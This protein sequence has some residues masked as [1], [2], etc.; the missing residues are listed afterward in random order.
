MKSYLTFFLVFLAC[1]SNAQQKVLG[2]YNST[3]EGY[4][5][6]FK[7]E[8]PCPVTVKVKFKLTNLQ[9][10]KPNQHLFILPA[11]ADSF[12]IMTLKKI[13]PKKAYSFSW[14]YDWRNGDVTKLNETINDAYFL[15]FKKGL[16]IEIGQ[17]YNGKF[18][19]HNENALDFSLPYGS[20]IYSVW[21][22]V[23]IDVV[24]N[25]SKSCP[26]KDCAIYN[27]YITIYHTNGTI[28]QYAHIKQNGSLLKIGDNVLKGQL[29][30]FSGDVGWSNGP[31]LHFVCYKETFEKETIITL[32]TKFLTGKGATREFLMEG[33]AYSR[34][35]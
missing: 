9:T 29:L 24:Q 32:K 17:G 22:G 34:N 14:S 27:N 7:N 31:H 6:L 2:F 10:D 13:D 26:T 15:P 3:Q 12:Q 33:K 19:H 23:V 5:I 4:Q 8:M 16:T 30:G 28:A 25:N 35:Y 21:E 18:S 1:Y 11:Q 20:E